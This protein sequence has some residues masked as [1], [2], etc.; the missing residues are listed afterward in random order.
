MRVAFAS[1]L[2]VEHLGFMQLMATLLPRGH[3]PTL[4][5]ST[6]PRRLLRSLVRERPDVVAFSL[7]SNNAL[8]AFDLAAQLRAAL[9]GT[10]IV[11]GGPHATL[12][13][14]AFRGGAFDAI[15]LGEGDLAFAEWLAELE[16]GGTGADV[17]NMWD[18][19]AEASPPA[20]SRPL[21]DPLDALP[22]AHREPFYRLPFF[23][24]SPFKTFLVSRGC[25]YSC[26]FCYNS[27]FRS[28]FAGRGRYRRV[29]SPERAVDEVEAVCNAYPTR[30]ALFEDDVFPYET[31]WLAR[32]VPLYRRRVGLPLILN[33]RADLLDE[34][35]VR[36]YREAGVRAVSFGVQSGSESRRLRQL[37]T[38][39]KDG[40]LI[41]AAQLLHRHGIAL[42]TYNIFG[43]PGETAEEV[44]DTI[45]FNR[46]LGAD[47]SRNG[48]FQPYAGLPLTEDTGFSDSRR[49][50]VRTIYYHS[51]LGGP[52]A[53]RIANLQ[54]FSNWMIR[55]AG[56]DRLIRWLTRLP[57]NPLFRGFFWLTFLNGIRQRLMMSWREVAGLV[58]RNAA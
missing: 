43:L 32:F 49:L 8:W 7:T 20:P 40:T 9:P 24:R 2:W 50:D 52:D 57:P 27:R 34:D 31:D 41:E 1:N 29:M 33:I 58:L 56:A 55:H 51:V 14:Q 4:H 35:N 45:L 13:P 15:C 30:L 44:L 16:Q 53:G 18:C 23:G 26:R 21:I 47:Y 38:R 25:A 10:R 5:I 19:T 11:A 6:R 17:A 3:T 42:M 39:V 46:A 36:L 12:F 22:F 54:N 28:L 37:G 48:M